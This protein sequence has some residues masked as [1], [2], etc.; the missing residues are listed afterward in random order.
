MF[1]KI[2]KPVTLSFLLTALCV[3]LAIW[4][5]PPGLAGD[6]RKC[7]GSLRSTSV[8]TC[9]GDATTCPGSDAHTNRTENWHCVNATGKHCEIWQKSSAYEVH[10][11]KCKWNSSQNR[12]VGDESTIKYSGAK[13]NSCNTTDMPSS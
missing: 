4:T 5:A 12:C 11:Y 8:Q 6:N 10:E 3:A 13:L 2:F 1:T 7:A 9:S